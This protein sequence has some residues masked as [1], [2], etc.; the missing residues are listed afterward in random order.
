MTATF[1]AVIHVA[2]KNIGA[3]PFPL[4][5]VVPAG[6]D[7]RERASICAKVSA[8]ALLGLRGGNG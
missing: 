3:Q 1:E 8:S 7:E 2:V 5:I 6:D 4:L